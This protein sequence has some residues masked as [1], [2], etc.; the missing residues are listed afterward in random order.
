MMDIMLLL[1]F[2]VMGECIFGNP[3]LCYCCILNEFN[4]SRAVGS[5]K[6]IHH[7]NKKPPREARCK[8]S[9][10]IRLLAKNSIII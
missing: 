5:L 7:W 1:H 3:L 4:N 9:N 2:T 6:I 10:F 8:W